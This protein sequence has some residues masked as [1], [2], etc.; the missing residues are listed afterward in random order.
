MKKYKKIINGVAFEISKEN[1]YWR[2]EN[3]DVIFASKT[4]RGAIKAAEGDNSEI[5]F[6]EWK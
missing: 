3:D 2:C 6:A 4:K 5:M 1:N